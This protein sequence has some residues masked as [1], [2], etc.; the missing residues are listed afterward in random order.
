[1][2]QKIQKMKKAAS[3]REEAISR[4]CDI[5]ALL[6][7]KC[8]WDKEQTH[9]S[10]KICMTEEA[11][12][13]CDAIDR[14][15]FDNLREELGDV[16]LQVVFHSALEEEKGLFDIVDVINDECDKMIRRHPHIFQGETAKSV[17]KVLEKWENIKRSEHWDMTYADE[18]KGVPKGM[19]ALMRSCKVQ[20]K[21]ANAGFD[22]DDVSGALDKLREET[23]EFIQAYEEGDTDHIRE[24]LGDVLF[25]VVNIARFLKIDPEAA[26]HETSEKFIRRF[27][28]M[29][30]IASDSGNDL[31]DMSL[32]EM[33]RIWDE[34]KK[35][36][37]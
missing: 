37:K 5:V 19:P 9:E 7:I 30:Q 1:M 10:L 15:D 8:P 29:E 36:E 33:D 18:L 16:M 4:L 6:R 21:A 12:E 23:G 24:E 20:K 3:T 22:W 26:L 2:D 34:V 31:R 25:S 11:Y 32:D 28:V 14:A 13:V 35:D 17:D 27:E